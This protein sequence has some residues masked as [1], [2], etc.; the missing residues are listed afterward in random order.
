M[1]GATVGEAIGLGVKVGMVAILGAASFLLPASYLMNMYA[2]HSAPMRIFVG[3]LGGLGSWVTLLVHALVAGFKRAP[4]HAIFPITQIYQEGQSG[5]LAP[6]HYVEKVDA[7]AKAFAGFTVAA[8]PAN[9][10]VFDDV[11]VQKGVVSPELIEKFRALGATRDYSEWAREAGS[12]R[13]A[14][15]FMLGVSPDAPSPSP[16]PAPAPAPAPV[17]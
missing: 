9:T 3:L 1:D 2:H 6:F 16:A 5:I 7:Y 17:L 8:D 10:K 13:D 15:A 4:F 14:A 12:L 11:P